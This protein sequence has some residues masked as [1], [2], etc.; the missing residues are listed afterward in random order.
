MLTIL[1]PAMLPS[2][3]GID[4]YFHFIFREER[5]IN[6]WL[7]LTCPYPLLGTW[8]ATQ[9]CALD[10]ES[11]WRPFVSQAGSQ[12]TKPHNP[13]CQHFFLL[14]TISQYVFHGNSD[15]PTQSLVSLLSVTQRKVGVVPSFISLFH[16]FSHHLAL[17]A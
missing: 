15:L 4:F 14:L 3:V 16:I 7:P 1:G 5:N 2:K 13:G 8:P 9:T 10:W 17:S 12:S 11:S 6:V